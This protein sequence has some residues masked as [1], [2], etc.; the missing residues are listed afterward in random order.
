MSMLMDKH[1]LFRA[2]LFWVLTMVPQGT[3]K[4][5]QSIDVR[6]NVANLNKLRNCT[7]IS[8]DLYIVLLLNTESESDYDDY[9]FPELQKI[10]GHLLLFQLK[11]FTSLGKMFPNLRLIRGLTLFRNYALVIYDLARIQEIGTSK[12][13]YIARGYVKVG[14]TPKLCYADTIKWNAIGPNSLAHI[15]LYRNDCLPCAQE[16][17]GYCWNQD[18]CQIFSDDCHAEC[19]GCTK[20]A[21]NEHCEVCKNFDND[22]VCVA[23]C[24]ENRY[25]LQILGK[26][27]SEKE[28]H[29]RNIRNN[30][31]G[32][33]QGVWFIYKGECRNTCPEETEFNETL[34][35]CVPCFNECYKSCEGAELVNSLTIEDM[36]GCTHIN[37]SLSILSLKNNYDRDDLFTS[38]KSVRY[39]RDYLKISRCDVI[40]DLQFLP[41]L[42]EIGGMNLFANKSLLA[43]DNRNLKKLWDLNANFTL[44]IKHGTIGFHDNDQLCLTEIQRFAHHVGINYSEI[45]VSKYSNGAYCYE[46]VDESLSVIVNERHSK[47][48]TITWENRLGREEFYY[49]IHYTDSLDADEMDQDVCS[50]PWTT[51]S[52]VKNTVQ[53]VGLKVFKKYHF[54]IR[55]YLRNMSVRR[56]P[57]RSFE[58]LP[59]DPDAPTFFNAVAVN[60]TAINLTWD[61]PVQTNG[62]LNSFKLTI[63]EEPQDPY[64]LEDRDYCAFPFT[65]EGSLVDR[66]INDDSFEDEPTE[67][68]ADAYNLN[69]PQYTYPGK[70]CK[71]T[72]QEVNI[73]LKN[74]MWLYLCDK[75]SQ[76]M[77]GIDNCKSYYYEILESN[78]TDPKLKKRALSYGAGYISTT[79][80]PANATFHVVTKLE[81]FTLYIFYIMACNEEDNGRKLC[82]SVLQARAKTLKNPYADL[83]TRIDIKL[84]SNNNLLVFWVP[85]QRPNGFIVAYHVYWHNDLEKLKMEQS[86][87][88]TAQEYAHEKGLTLRGLRPDTYHVSVQPV[89]L[90]GPGNMSEPKSYEIPQP[91][92]W[93]HISLIVI[94]LG[95]LLVICLGAIW[96]VRMLRSPRSRSPISALANINPEYTTLAYRADEWEID[97]DDIELGE[98][99]GQGAFGRVFFGRIMSKDL[100]C[101]VKTINEE[102]SDLDR[103]TFLDEA[104][105]MKGFTQGPHVVKLMGVVSQGQPP[106][107]LMELMERGDLK[108]YLLRLR[109]SSQTLTSNEIY[110]MAIEIADGLAY[111]K[112][113]K[114]VHRDLAVRNCMINNNKTVK[115]GDFGMTRDI[116]QSDYYKK[117]SGNVLLPVR[118]MAP[119]SIADG[120]NTY[121]TDIWSY[122]IVLWEIVTLASQPYHG[123]SNEEVIN[124]VLSKGVLTRPEECPNLL[125]EIMER[126]WEWLPKLRP[127]CCEIVE[128]LEGCVGVDF[129]SISFFHSPIGV[130]YFDQAA[131]REENPPALGLHGLNPFNEEQNILIESNPLSEVLEDGSPF[132]D[133]ES[134]PSCSSQQPHRITVQAEVYELKSLKSQSSSD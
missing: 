123:M 14:K 118:W 112:S 19:L 94:G 88:I 40:N 75:N 89:S 58:T 106:Y 105:T 54:Y 114:Y 32:A 107:V 98:L 73:R 35:N 44:Q 2:T 16:C 38:L 64:L 116:Y 97:R 127:T 134:S 101:A 65:A 30:S 71:P 29:S 43:H 120:V 21:S 67:G 70:P 47:N 52:T 84:T 36:R 55:I 102:A 125:W 66:A 82:S 96:A 131:M 1:L 3:T 31:P 119:E 33:N 23:E 61:H 108:R 37:G 24:P 81:P 17:G 76:S 11:H 18:T 129:E 49:L 60:D 115:I 34:Q 8:G 22:G 7:E 124:F 87:C 128:M 26:C 90:A 85:P 117:G 130:H 57:I 13:T 80:L 72:N 45:D 39:I 113:R 69:E 95:A 74:D 9:V 4:I 48:V 86:Q 126:C 62:I 56:T 133:I 27:I 79:S 50:S 92:N 93:L 104:S 122:G 121:D 100:N 68:L 25:I 63:Y 41:N 20:P 111:L 53:L 28:C 51:V 83:I 99:I 91:Y 10:S 77:Y 46:A 15:Q 12:L 6:N 132:F 109:D 59:D 42:R 78:L 5:C 103:M 110:R